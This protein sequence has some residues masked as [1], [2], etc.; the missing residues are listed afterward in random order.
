MTAALPSGSVPAMTSS[1]PTAAATARAVGLVVPGQQDRVQPERAQFGDGGGGGRLDRVGDRDGAAGRAVPA[2][3]HRGPAV[4]LPRPALRGQVGRDGQAVV[5]EQPLAP[6]Q[7]LAAVDGAARAEPRQ[8]PEA[9]GLRQRPAS[10]S[11]AALIAAATA[12]SDACS[13]APA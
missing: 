13:T 6:D 4:L 8:R 3:Q 7:D 12:C 1:M 11:A 10:A 2:D 5:G 9:L